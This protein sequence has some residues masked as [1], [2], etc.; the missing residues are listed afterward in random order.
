MMDAYK[1]YPASGHLD[2]EEDK[3]SCQA[4]PRPGFHRKEITGSDAL[5]Q[6]QL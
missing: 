4:G 2:Y 1:L 3:E 6:R 5:D